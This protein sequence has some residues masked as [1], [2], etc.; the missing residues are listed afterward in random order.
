[1][2]M[3]RMVKMM[4]RTAMMT[5]MTMMMTNEKDSCVGAH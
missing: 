2:M 1:M 5:M 4:I 3:I